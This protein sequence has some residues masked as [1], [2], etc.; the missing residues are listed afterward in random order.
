MFKVHILTQCERCNGKAYLPAGEA[1]DYKGEK[2]MRY[3]PCP[4]CEGSGN[5]ERWITFA[6]FINLLRASQAQCLHAHTS[7]RGGFH[8][9]GN[10]IWDD[11]TEVCDDCGAN[12]DRLRAQSQESEDCLETTDA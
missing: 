9:N 11:I 5:Q 4:Y 1:E 7:Y 12:L 6:E 8:Y 3:Q 2:Y 10:D